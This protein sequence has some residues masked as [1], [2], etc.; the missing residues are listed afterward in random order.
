MKTLIIA[1]LAASGATA[2]YA[3]TADKDARG[4]FR[5]EMRALIDA[6]GMDVANLANL[7][8]ER[9][10]ARFEA[11]DADGDGVV[12]REQFLAAA[13]ERAAARFERMKPNEDGIVTRT[14]REAGR[15]HRDGPRTERRDGR[16][17]MT[18]EERAER[19][20]ARVTEQFER[21]DT[22]SDGMISPEE[23]AAGQEARGERFAQRREERAERREARAERRAEMP[24]AMRDVHAKMRDMMRDGMNLEGFSGLMQERASAMFDTLDA[25]GNGELSA[26]EFVAKVP[27]RAERVFARMDR[28]EDGLVTSEDRPRGGKH[29]GQHERGGKDAAPRE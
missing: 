24:E 25:D 14:G 18:Q 8:Q 22:N 5:A 9:E 21:L 1:L 19:R 13:G 23:F 3:E 4:G 28:N 10:Q 6:D 11:L 16:A 15:L 2:A 17:E 26:K 29:W 12:T 7:M 20:S 27:E